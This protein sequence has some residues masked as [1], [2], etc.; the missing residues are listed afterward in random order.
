MKGALIG[1]FLMLFVS[2][3]VG[4]LVVGMVWAFNNNHGVAMVAF[5]T[6][7]IMALGALIGWGR[8]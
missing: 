2:A 8:A 7:F 5:P 6:L 4:M 3:L 1:A